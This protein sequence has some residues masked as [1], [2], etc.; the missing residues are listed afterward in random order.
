MNVRLFTGESFAP[1]NLP[2]PMQMVIER[3]RPEVN[4]ARLFL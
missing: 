3:H 2:S 1:Q 4:A